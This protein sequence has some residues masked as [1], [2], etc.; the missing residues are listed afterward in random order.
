MRTIAERLETLRTNKARTACIDDRLYAIDGKICELDDLIKPRGYQR[1]WLEELKERQQLLDTLQQ[2]RRTR[3][4]G[5]ERQ[6]VGMIERLKRPHWKKILRI[7]YIE[8]QGLTEA[9]AAV[10][11]DSIERTG[12]TAANYTSKAHR[13]RLAA[14]AHLEKMQKPQRQEP[15]LGA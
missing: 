1:E 6:L 4:E 12:T 8:G 7:L 5:E 2:E 9:A 14:I 11:A 10:Y 15:K 3:E 13:A